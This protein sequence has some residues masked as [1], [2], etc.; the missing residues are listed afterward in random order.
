LKTNQHT[1]AIGQARK[2][3]NAAILM[4]NVDAI[5][6]F[7]SNDY[8]IVTARGIQSKGVDEQRRRWSEAFQLDPLLLYRRRTR[9]LRCNERLGVAEELGG[10]VGRLSSSYQTTLVAGVYS[11]KWQRQDDGDW[12]IQ[13]EVFTMLKS[14]TYV[15]TNFY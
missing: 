8:H 13:S 7:F 10:W 2:R 14:K 3:F 5:C 4:R 6:A 9:E 1:H 12:L 15:N 11:A